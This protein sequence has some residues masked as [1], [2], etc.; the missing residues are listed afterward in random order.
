M[1]MVA[2]LAIRHHQHVGDDTMRLD[3]AVTEVSNIE[4]TIA[5]VSDRTGILW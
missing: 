5:T 1:S 2:V 4:P 3:K